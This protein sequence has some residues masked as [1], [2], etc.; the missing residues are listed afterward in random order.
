MQNTKTRKKGMARLLELAFTRKVLSPLACV[1]SVISV[2]VSFT[3]YITIYYVIRELVA[4]F[5]DLSALDTALMIRLG[6][7]AVGGRG[8][9]NRA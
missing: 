1:L 8:R 2:I 4:H 7:L 6:W 5:N 9:G 3:P